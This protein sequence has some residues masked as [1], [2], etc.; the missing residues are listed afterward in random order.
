MISAGNFRRRLQR[1]RSSRPSAVIAARRR[2]WVL[3]RAALER[4]S[5]AANTIE[6]KDSPAAI[7]ATIAAAQAFAALFPQSSEEVEVLNRIIA[8]CQD[9]LV[10]S[11]PIAAGQEIVAA[12]DELLP[13]IGGLV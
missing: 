4:L 1:F 8:A 13:L 10:R 6:G 9:L 3:L 7:Q 5:D 11:R 12:V 2:S